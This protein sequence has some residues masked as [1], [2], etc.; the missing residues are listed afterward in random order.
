VRVEDLQGAI[1]HHLDGSTR[2][3]V[4]V[5]PLVL[6]GKLLLR[7]E[8]QSKQSEQSEQSKQSKY[9]QKERDGRPSATHRA[10]EVRSS[11]NSEQVR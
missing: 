1:G 11:E 9:S 2:Q 7:L 5:P 3:E 6:Q 10:N 8:W 4:G